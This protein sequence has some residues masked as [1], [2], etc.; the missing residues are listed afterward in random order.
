MLPNSPHVEKVYI[1][2]E[3]LVH[4]YDR[5][6]S[7]AEA[8]IANGARATDAPVFGGMDPKLLASILILQWADVGGFVTT[9]MAKDLRVAVNAANR[10]SYWAL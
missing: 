4:A 5:S 1:G 8:I 10:L 6:K 2:E 9:L 7:V 3:G